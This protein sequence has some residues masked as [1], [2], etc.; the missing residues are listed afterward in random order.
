MRG[1][2]FHFSLGPSN[3]QSW[4]LTGYFSEFQK[5]QQRSS[6]WSSESQQ[7]LLET[8]SSMFT[9]TAMVLSQEQ[10]CPLVDI[11]QCL[12]TFSVVPAQGKLLLASGR[13]RMSSKCTG[14][15][16]QQRSPKFIHFWG[17]KTLRN[18]LFVSLTLGIAPVK[19]LSGCWTSG[20]S[21]DLRLLCS[22]PY[23]DWR[24]NLVIIECNLTLPQGAVQRYSLHFS[25][26][27]QLTGRLLTLIR[28]S[29]KHTT[30]TVGGWL[31][32]TP[33]YFCC[34]LLGCQFTK[35]LG[36][37]PNLFTPLCWLLSLCNV[38]NYYRN[39]GK[40]KY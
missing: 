4:P 28:P 16:P 37:F 3:G 21:Q 8:E 13:S 17:W 38:I 14:Q 24:M 1:S 9:L 2:H 11:K 19:L 18:S 15:P 27:T 23:T 30:L 36:L 31:S 25:H 7:N 5:R 22:F 32:R 26:L 35:S 20:D 40:E 10:F 12:E 33:V 39:L 34:H 6:M 29:L